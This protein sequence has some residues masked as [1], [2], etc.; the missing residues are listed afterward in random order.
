MAGASRTP[1]TCLSHL[2]DQGQCQREELAR[3]VNRIGALAG[4]PLS[5]SGQSVSMWIRGHQPKTQVRAIVV[6]A[7]SRE[8]RT[9]RHARGSRSHPRRVR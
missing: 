1:N 7:L 3:A 2:L 4:M 8:A 6:A 5:H 9:S